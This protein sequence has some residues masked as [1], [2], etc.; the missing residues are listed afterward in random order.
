MIVE[1]WLYA[2]CWNDADWLPFFFR[3]YDPVVTR[4]VFFDDGSTDGSLDLLQAHPRAEVRPFERSH[5]DSFALSEI[6]LSDHV[7]KEA[8][9]SADWVIV[10]DVDEHL[11]HPDLAG[12][13]RQARSR[14]ITAIPALGY[15]MLSDTWPDAGSQLATT[16][17]VGAPW[18]HMDKLSI[19]DPSAVEE[20][21]FILGRHAA[22]PI[23]RVVVPAV[24]EVLNLHYKY[25]SFERTLA[26]HREEH[27][28]LGPID[29]ANG[30]GA[31]YTWGE[32]QLREHWEAMR[33]AAIDLRDGDPGRASRVVWWRDPGSG[34]ALA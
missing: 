29:L 5:P 2:L 27:S 34:L 7:W 23:G 30:W 19:I 6:A 3:H 22:R 33:A 8:R 15:Q 32:E 14:G 26:R 24:D 21:S 25:L 31:Q 11:H 18:Y 13:L 10:C 17:T 16:L 28:G 12:Y 1:T 4:Y 9:G 20:W